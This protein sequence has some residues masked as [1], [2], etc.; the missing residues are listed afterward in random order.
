MLY[1]EI[2]LRSGAGADG[3]TV[4]W[5][6]D[7]FPRNMETALAFEER[8]GKPNGVIILECARETAR[9]RYLTRRREE[10]DDNAKFEKRFDE[11][12]ENMKAIRKH[13]EGNIKTVCVDGSID[14]Y[15]VDFLNALPWFSKD[16]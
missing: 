10:T 15:F 1:S 14:D 3:I 11:Y 5:L 7:G 4:A 6:I 9:C 8:M 2:R 13:Y 12:V 16:Q